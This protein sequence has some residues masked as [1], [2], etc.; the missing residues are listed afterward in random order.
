MFLLS[1]FYHFPLGHLQSS[2]VQYTFK[3]T[4][5]PHPPFLREHR[6]LF[7]VMKVQL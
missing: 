4:K 3:S 5:Q 2:S 6:F 1:S 7:L